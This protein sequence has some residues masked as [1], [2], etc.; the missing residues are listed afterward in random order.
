MLATSYLSRRW[1]AKYFRLCKSLRPCS[2]WERVGSL[3]FVT[4]KLSFAVYRLFSAFSLYAESCIRYISSWIT[5]LKYC[6]TLR[7]HSLPFA[8]QNFRSFCSALFRVSDF[9]LTL[10]KFQL[11]KALVQLVMLGWKC[12]HSYTCILSTSS[13]TTGLTSLCYERSHLVVG[14]VLICFQHLSAW[15]TATGR[16]PLAR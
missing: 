2:G 16:L 10:R 11:E 8:S 15:N 5:P 9:V 14:F 13:S 3:R 4:N 6:F 1:P 12:C 7:S